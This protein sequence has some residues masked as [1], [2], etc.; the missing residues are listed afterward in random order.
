VFGERNNA[1]TT[2]PTSFRKPALPKD[3]TQ[4]PLAGSIFGSQIFGVKAVLD[5]PH[6]KPNTV[7]RSFLIQSQRLLGFAW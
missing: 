1:N 5:S 6:P 2:A 4:P 7:T 3:G